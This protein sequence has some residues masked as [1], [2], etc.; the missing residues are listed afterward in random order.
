MAGSNA[1]SG[2]NL[3]DVTGAGVGLNN[4][5]REALDKQWQAAADKLPSRNGLSMGYTTASDAGVTFTQDQYWTA[6]DY[7]VRNGGLRVGV[8]G[9]AP[10]DVPS[11]VVTKAVNVESGVSKRPIVYRTANS[12]YGSF[13]FGG[14]DFTGA[15]SQ[16]DSN[17][18]T[19][20]Y[21]KNGYPRIQGL[22]NIGKNWW[23]GGVELTKLASDGYQF[24]TGGNRSVI[25]NQFYPESA[26]LN[27]IN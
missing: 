19:G 17:A 14:I 25:T 20:F 13:L 21:A 4:A 9:P 18:T 7:A 8:T 3:N 27:A 24:F 16:A 26:S 11:N 6:D 12:G 10:R 23:D 22:S 2:I 5:Q 15:T 1:S